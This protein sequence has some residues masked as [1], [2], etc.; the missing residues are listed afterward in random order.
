MDR[1]C[2][3]ELIRLLQI[4]VASGDATS[5][6]IEKLRELLR[7]RFGLTFARSEDMWE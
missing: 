5:G 2:T 6:Q 3:D 7:A 1:L 4:A